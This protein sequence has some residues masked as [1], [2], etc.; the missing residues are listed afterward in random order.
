MAA[1]HHRPSLFARIGWILEAGLAAVI[2]VA[3]SCVGGT[4][5]PF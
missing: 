1:A 4:V 3:L 2:F 5:Y